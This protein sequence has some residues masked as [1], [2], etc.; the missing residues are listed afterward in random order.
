MSHIYESVCVEN[1]P[2]L[3][4]GEI[5]VKGGRIGLLMGY[6]DELVNSNKHYVL[7]RRLP[8]DSKS[9]LVWHTGD[10]GS[11]DR[12]GNVYC[13]GRLGNTVK[14]NDCLVNKSDVEAVI[15]RHPSVYDCVVG[16]EK[17]PVSGNYLYAYVEL[18]EGYSLTPEEVKQ[19]VKTKLP[20]YC[21]PKVVEF[22]VLDRTC[23]GKLKRTDTVVAPNKKLSKQLVYYAV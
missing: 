1:V 4:N 22:R 11:I 18:K 7:S 6:L 14:V 17:D 16:S 23:N 5:V 9:C 21:R 20:D 19:Y 12:E 15:K 2:G 8:T 3:E 10:A 13:D